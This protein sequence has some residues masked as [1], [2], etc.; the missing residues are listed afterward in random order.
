MPIPVDQGLALLFGSETRVRTLAPLAG[1]NTPLT[2]YRIAEV[3]ELPRTK[4]YE[5]LARLKST[6][7]VVGVT[8]AAGQTLWRL[9]DPD[10]RSLL[11]RRMRIYFASDLVR[12]ASL[13]SI[14]ARKVIARSRRMGLPA[15]V[16][17]P[18]FTPRNAKDYRRPP[19]KDALLARL[20]LRTS[21][22]TRRRP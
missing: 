14:D 18:G 13:R 8:G 4:V 2:A 11:R 7:W 5:E 3:A 15:G 17:Q 12:E 1:S 19:Q 22:R 20:G 10:V 9:T 21:R 6:G 16:L